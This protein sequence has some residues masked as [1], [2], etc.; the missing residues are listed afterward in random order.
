VRDGYELGGGRSGPGEQAGA[1]GLAS[2]PTQAQCGATT[3]ADGDKLV[4]FREVCFYG[5][6]PNNANTDGDACRDGREVASINGNTAVDVIDLQQ[7]ASEAGAYTL[8]GSPVKV[9]FD[10]TKDGNIN[11]VD[12]QQSAAQ[13]GSCP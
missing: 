6:D 4:T 10:I 12:L 2:R 13:N 7:I 1:A 8:P 11:V 5:T 9:N 3:D